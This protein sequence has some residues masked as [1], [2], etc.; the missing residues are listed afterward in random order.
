MV[1]ITL[2]IAP[3]KYVHLVKE[4]TYSTFTT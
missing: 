3:I 2:L 1:T 4:D